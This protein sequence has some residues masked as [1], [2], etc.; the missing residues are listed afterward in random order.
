MPV[1]M[2]WVGEETGGGRSRG[3]RQE[4]RSHVIKAGQASI[5]LLFWKEEAE[6][7]GPEDTK[8]SGETQLRAE[9]WGWLVWLRR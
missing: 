8:G 9:T 3:K 4:R 5:K 2:E 6:R 1:E 7:G